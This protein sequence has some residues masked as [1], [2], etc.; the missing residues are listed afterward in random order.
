MIARAQPVVRGAP[1]D[2]GIV[3]W[4]RRIALG[5]AGASFGATVASVADALWAKTSVST[6]SVPFL[7]LARLD[8]GLNVPFALVVGIGVA[9]F[10]LVIEPHRSRS[11]SGLWRDLLLADLA[12]RRRLAACLGPIA[13]SLPIWATAVGHFAKKAMAAE[14]SNL[15]SGVSMAL[16]ALVLALVALTI[17]LAVGDLLD[18]LL[19]RA[20]VELDPRKALLAGL[21]V[22]SAIVV[23]GV[24]I[25]TTG[26]E[27][28]WLGIW[29]VLKRPELDLRAPLLLGAIAVAA[30]GVPHLIQRTPILA[31][32]LGVLP[33]GFTYEGAVRL[34]RFPELASALERGA[35]LGKMSLAALRRAT[36]RDHDGYS[37]FFG[38]GDCDDH[39]AR[40]NPQALDIPG[41][42][43]DEDCSGSD[44]PVPAPREVAPVE[45]TPA[46]QASLLPQD[47]NV[48]LIT[49]DTLRAD[50]GFQGNPKPLSPNLDALAARS[51]VFDRAYSLASYTGKSIGPLLIGKYPSETHRGWGHF[52]KYTADDTMV[53]QRL[54]K[55]G[56]HTVGVQAHCYFSAAFGLS[57]GFDVW[58]SRAQPP[59]GSDQDNDATITG[60]ALTDAAIAVLSDL[61]NTRAPFF[62]WIHYLDPHSEYA[63]HPEAP[64]L[65]KGMRAAYDGEVWY[66]D[67]QIGRLLEFFAQQPWG[68]KT[69]IVV[70]SDHGE[71]FGE[72]GMIRHG[73][74]VWEELVRV[75]FLFAI[76]GVTPHRVAVRRSAIDLVPTLLDLMGLRMTEPESPFDF[77]SGHSLASDIAMPP[78][79]R[80]AERDIL[81][82]MPAGPNND[83][84]RAFIH[85]GRKLY[86]SNA[87]RYQLFDLESDPAEKND[88]SGDK[89]LLADMKARYQEFRG[90]LRE[91]MV[92]RATA[93]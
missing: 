6:P 82:D 53:A 48:I 54:Q 65:G 50:L 27:G 7:P 41:N 39:D 69:A 88:L 45:V 78:G 14:G 34:A 35:P 87:V 22:A 44:A 85:E 42:G 89:D 91:V 38:G 8:V 46:S 83:E 40:I 86:I 17:A 31:L 21:A 33:L 25:G 37:P 60:G 23:L 32:A 80:P 49:V 58:S 77:L 55:A 10:G 16:A 74:E 84:R 75:P 71:A 61:G 59:A 11:P 68:D 1:V 19:D 30:Y 18:R 56:V 28:G 51:V 81:V 26:A 92:R 2:A 73:F 12:R 3:G 93:P 70:T 62:T 79:Y 52:N 72:H 63:K 4:P 76:P 24:S 43:I 67:H 47:L 5:V 20:R 90:G 13:I 9:L 64:D 36:D 29:G 57:R 15:T 66:A